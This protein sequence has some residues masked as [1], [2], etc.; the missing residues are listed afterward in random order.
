MKTN[1]VRRVKANHRLIYHG[2]YMML[3]FVVMFIGYAMASNCQDFKEVNLYFLFG[4]L[5]VIV[6]AVSFI[7]F[8]YDSEYEKSD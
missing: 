7:F 2:Y 8:F 3:S 5:F 4:T 1:N 6:G